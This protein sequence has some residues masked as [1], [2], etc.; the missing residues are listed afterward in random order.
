[1]R[2]ETT[3][4]RMA[5]SGTNPNETR[6]SRQSV[7]SMATDAPTMSRNICPERTKP[8]WTKLRIISTSTV[9]LDIK[10]PVCSRSWNAKLRC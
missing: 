1:M 5:I 2:L 7:S 8:I 9:D 3:T 6:A 4:A 10:L